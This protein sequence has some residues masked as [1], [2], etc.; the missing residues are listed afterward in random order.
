M[1]VQ[2]GGGT[3]IQKA[4]G[5]AQDL[6]DVPRRAI[7]V[8]ISDFYEGASAEM[9]VR[10]VAALTAQGSQVL[11]LAALDE[12]ARPD[13][14][15]ELAKRLVKVGAHVGA[16]TPGQLAAWIAEKVRA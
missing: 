15:R 2:L 10:R 12:Q 6:I 4:V 11:G 7:V 9:L 14:D 3:D 5:Y 1:K 13:Y 8:L 16:M